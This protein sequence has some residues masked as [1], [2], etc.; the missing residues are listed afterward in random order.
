MGFLSRLMLFML[1]NALIV[2]TISI[3]LWR[4]D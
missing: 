4:R 3:L 2:F 1:V